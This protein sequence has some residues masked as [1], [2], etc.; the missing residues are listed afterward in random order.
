V[1]APTPDR[2]F[3][4]AEANAALPQVR[5]AVADLRRAIAAVRASAPVVEAFAA[6]AAA[7]GGTQPSAEER[8]ARERFRDAEEAAGSALDRLHRIGVLVKDADRGLVDFPS[9]RDGEIVELCWL[10]GEP[11]VAHWHHVGAGF[12]GR[13]PLA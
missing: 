10:D 3:T 9:L 6:R 13:Q 1:D 5:P 4:A 12:A 2:L 7:S 8:A 11:A